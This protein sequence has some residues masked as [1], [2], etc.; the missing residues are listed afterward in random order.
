MNASKKSKM[1]SSLLAISKGHQVSNKVGFVTEANS[2]FSDGFSIDGESAALAALGIPD[3]PEDDHP[4]FDRYA[5]LQDRKAE[6][7][8][9][10]RDWMHRQGADDLVDY[11]DTQAMKQLGALVGQETDSMT[12]HT[13]E[14]YRM[15]M[16]RSSDPERRLQQIPGGKRA[17]TSLRTLLTLTALDN[18][19]ADWALVEY[20]RNQHKVMKLLE[21]KIQAGQ[22]ALEAKKK[23]GLS[24]SVLQ[25]S[26]PKSIEL[27]FKSAYGYGVAELI[28]AFDYFVRVQKTLA[29]KNIISD[30]QE[31][32]QINEVTRL[33]RGYSNKVAL[34]EKWLTRPEFKDLSR[35]DYL[36]GV[37]KEAAE[38]VEGM[39]AIFG[40]IPA[41]IYSGEVAP[42]HSRRR[43]KLSAQE[44]ALLASVGQALQ[45]EEDEAEAQAHAQGALI[46]D[47]APAGLV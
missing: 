18:P 39:R 2:P 47:S 38:R 27:G 32:N 42:S 24:Y 19:Y 1:A 20:E 46:A 26:E 35:S 3:S 4:L 7:V 12:L 21:Q 43:H 23:I 13:K 6:L 29:R 45:Q 30:E 14:A 10:Q 22:N 9:K 5:E 37:P 34:F 17:A 8:R 36:P 11:K 28:M 40:A 44:R 15:F 25:S 41:Q 16:G 33:I 31:R